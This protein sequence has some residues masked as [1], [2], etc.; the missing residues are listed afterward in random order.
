[1]QQHTPPSSPSSANIVWPFQHHSSE[2]HGD[3][4]EA[5]RSTLP[6]SDPVGHS[7]GSSSTNI[8]LRLTPG[9]AS[10]LQALFSL[11]YPVAMESSHDSLVFDSLQAPSKS[12]GLAAPSVNQAY[13]GEDA[14]SNKNSGF[15]GTKQ[16]I[17]MNPTLDPNT[18][19]NTIHFVLAG[20]GQWINSDCFDISTVPYPCYDAIIK[21]FKS[22]PEE[23]RQVILVANIF[24][25]ASKSPRQN[26]RSMAIANSLQTEASNTIA[27]FYSMQPSSHHEEDGCKA[28]QAVN[29]VME[30]VLVWRFLSPI[31]T[32]MKLMEAIAPVFRRAC[33]EPPNRLVNLPSLLLSELFHRSQFAMIDVILCVAT[34]RPMFYRYDTSY[35]LEM[36]SLFD[37]GYGMER[38]YGVPDRFIIILASINANYEDFGINLSREDI[39]EIENRIRDVKHVPGPYSSPIFTSRRR[40]LQECWR[41]AMYVYLFMFL[42]GAKA[43]DPR[44]VKAVSAFM[45]LLDGAKPACSLDAFLLIPMLIV[46]V[47]TLRKSHRQM[48]YRHMF[49][50]QYRTNFG[51]SAGDCLL[52]LGNIWIRTEAEQR[53]AVWSDMRIACY[54]VTGV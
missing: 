7:S 1:M 29:A 2:T 35:T 19:D 8:P 18:V 12:C 51:V 41:Q 39:I 32:V 27:R 15:Q 20:Y 23:R 16:L 3:N 54:Q 13:Q 14:V 43:N 40:A 24:S 9:Q 44:V 26:E 46:G 10:L 42:C 49:P 17:S 5:H 11:A 45:Q 37:H 31:T 33:P 38:L 50:I 53:V 22:S 36:G 30:V 6:P 48:L 25:T 52:Q 21:R 34:G 47:A 28:L 4:S